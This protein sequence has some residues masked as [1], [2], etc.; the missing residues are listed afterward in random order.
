MFAIDAERSRKA[1]RTCATPMKF[2]TLPGKT[3]G[4]KEYWPTCS[5]L[6]PVCSSTKARRVAA[7]S[8]V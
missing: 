4:A 7:A 2:S 3:E 8:G 1:D 6:V 5:S